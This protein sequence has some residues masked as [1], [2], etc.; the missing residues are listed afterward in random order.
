M[1]VEEE[2]GRNLKRIKNKWRNIPDKFKGFEALLESDSEGEDDTSPSGELSHNSVTL[3]C[4]TW[5]FGFLILICK[6]M[7]VYNYVCVCSYF[8]YCSM[9]ESTETRT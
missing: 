8:R 3:N 1:S 6:H 2:F 7:H 5:G 4:H 9:H